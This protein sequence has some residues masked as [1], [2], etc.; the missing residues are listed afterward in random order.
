MSVVLVPPLS[1]FAGL[2]PEPAPPRRQRVGQTTDSIALIASNGSHGCIVVHDGAGI[3]ADIEAIG[4]NSL[5]HHGLDD[6]PDGLSIW[7]GRLTGGRC[8][9][10]GEDYETELV[11]TFRDLT[12]AEWLLLRETG[13]PWSY[14]PL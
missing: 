5:D 4:N 12:D 9:E 10:F 7:E 11:G 14:E 1:I 13:E 3:E 2:S 6:A 8:G